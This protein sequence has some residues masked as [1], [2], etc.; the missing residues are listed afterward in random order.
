MVRKQFSSS[1][2][3]TLHMSNA[4]SLQ[5]IVLTFNIYIYLLSD[6]YIYLISD[7]SLYE[8]SNYRCILPPNYRF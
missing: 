2:F 8:Y 7:L 4:S 3:L 6:T 5:N 1:Y